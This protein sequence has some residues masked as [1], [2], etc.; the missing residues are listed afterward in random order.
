MASS[1]YRWLTAE[2]DPDVI[3]IDL[4]ETWT[5]GPV[6]AILDRVVAT[7]ERGVPGS[8][9][10]ATGEDAAAVVRGRPI[11]VLSMLVL[12]VVALSAIT[13][14]LAASLTASSFAIHLVAAVLS[15]LGTRSER[16]L[17]ELRETRLG[18]L[19]VAAFEPPEPPASARETDEP[20]A[21]LSS[22]EALTNG[23]DEDETTNEPTDE[24]R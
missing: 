5:V 3:V 22:K 17:A 24:R 4:R 2:P 13:S 9:A 11:A 12:P 23:S 21:P 7:L 10:V 15:A 20:T 19:L 8:A 14:A 1:L 6:I 16:S 18:R